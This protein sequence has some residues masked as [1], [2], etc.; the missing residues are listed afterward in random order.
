ML[1]HPEKILVEAS[2]LKYPFCQKVIDGFKNRCQ[3]NI[4]PN[5]SPIEL[6]ED[7]IARSLGKRILY[8]KEFKGSAFKLCPGFSEN[9]LCCN[10]FVLDLVENCPLECSY[11]ILQVFLNKPV[12]T[13]HVNVEAIIETMV[14]AVKSKP[15]QQF[16]IGTGEHSDSLA[17]DPVFGINPFLVESFSKLANATLE[18]KTKTNAIE[19][20]LSLNHNGRTV[21]AWSINPPEII[22]SN[23][24]KTA[25]LDDRLKAAAT[26][27]KE[28]YKVAFHFD[29]L[30]HYQNWQTGYAETISKL[31]KTIA[32]DK[33]AWISLGTLRYI[34]KLKQIAEERFPKTSIF[35]EEFIA[36]QDGKMR[37]IKP[38]RKSMLASVSNWI[39]ERGPDVPLYLCME[40][41]FMW[42]R[43]FKEYPATP[44]ELELYLNSHLGRASCQG[45]SKTRVRINP[46]AI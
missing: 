21:V 15:Q 37:Y 39:A 30:I 14:T 13:F 43:L 17:L 8:L 26:L 6:T 38:I 28:G 32:P 29:P 11:C 5:N 42:S 7:G 10:Y 18:L 22:R 25:S 2:A 24:H 33:I 46:D 45:A 12:I 1:Y 40:Q 41:P 20:L 16:R 23:E 9:T 36:A 19:S 31:F 35:A 27:C 34:P 44:T 4:L 3:V